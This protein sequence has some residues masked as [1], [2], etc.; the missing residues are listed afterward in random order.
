MAKIRQF[1]RFIPILIILI[2]SSYIS[3]AQSYYVE[4]KHTFFGGVVAGGNFSQVDGDNFAGYH[5]TGLNVGGI[6]YTRLTAHFAPSLEILYSEK[7]SKSNGYKH[8]NSNK[9]DIHTYGISLNY[10]EIPVMINYFDKNNANFGLGFSYS[11]LVGSKEYATTNSSAFDDTLHFERFP[12]KSNDVNFIVGGSLRF[13]K[14]FYLNLR[15]QYSLFPVRK[16]MHTEFGRADQYNNIWTF[17]LMYLFGD[18]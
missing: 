4:D 17:R 13:F 14:G 1:D 15:F 6:V 10:A 7:G 8:V 18:K 3:N 2:I 5:K 11:Q 9:Y 12:F 16:T